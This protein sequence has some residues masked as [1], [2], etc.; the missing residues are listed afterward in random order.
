LDL[1]IKSYG[2]LKFLGE[3]W[4]WRACAGA[5]QQELTTM[6]AGPA[7]EQRSP[8]GRGLQSNR[9]RASLPFLAI[10]EFFSLSFFGVTRLNWNFGKMGIQHP[11]FLKLAPTLGSVESSN[12][13]GAWR[14]HF[15]PNF[16]FAKIR[17]HLD[18]HIHFRDFSFVKK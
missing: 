2:C 18:H 14:F 7:G 17:G 4:A 15:F 11:H 8:A 6:R 1:W 16:I 10:F 5:N 3:V 13:H 12:P 9:L